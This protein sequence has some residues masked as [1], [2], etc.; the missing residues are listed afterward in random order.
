MLGAPLAVSAGPARPSGCSRVGLPRAEGMRFGMPKDP[1]IREK[2]TRLRQAA[3]KFAADTSSVTRRI[4]TRPRSRAGAICNRTNIEFT[5][6]RLREPID[7]G[8]HG[9]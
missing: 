5:L 8:N 4:D 2:F 7:S 3:K 1:F 9:G 6:K